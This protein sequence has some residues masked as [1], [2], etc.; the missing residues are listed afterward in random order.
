MATVPTSYW[1]PSHWFMD[2]DHHAFPDF[3]PFKVLFLNTESRAHLLQRASY[4]LHRR[5]PGLGVLG[6]YP[7]LHCR[8]FVALTPVSSEDKKQTLY[9]QSPSTA[10]VVC[11][12]SR[13]QVFIG[14]EDI[15]LGYG[16]HWWEVEQE[17]VRGLRQCWMTKEK[18]FTAQKPGQHH[19]TQLV[20]AHL[21]DCDEAVKRHPE[22]VA[23][24]FLA[25]MHHLNQTHRKHQMSISDESKL[26]NT[27]LNNG[28]YSSIETWQLTT[29]H[30]SG[31][32]PWLA[33]A[34]GFVL[35]F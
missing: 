33:C 8:E 23:P 20:Q 9:S 25:K 26:G 12:P 35:F 6:F 34:H 18:F 31:L 19:L 5:I 3:W 1:D 15:L 21:A 30:D 17:Y 29:I 2:R 22:G 24:L 14:S 11:K 7:D 28:L 13:R 27:L 10:L 32:E 4:S 16:I